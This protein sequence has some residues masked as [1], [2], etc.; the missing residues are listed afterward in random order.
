MTLEGEDVRPT[1]EKVKEAVFSS[2]QFELEGRRVLDLFAGSGQLGI[3]ALSRGA[4]KCVF[5]DS[6]RDAVRVI[7]Q[8][9]AHTG[10]EEE[11]TVLCADSTRFIRNTRETFDVVFIDPPYRHGTAAAVLPDAAARLSPG[12]VI[13]CETEEEAS[14]PDSVGPF[15]K[16]RDRRYGRTR[17]AIYRAPVPEDEA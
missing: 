10:F 2:I 17:V 3:E 12:G 15:V 11:S 9:V 16:D 6:S 7:E 8:N 5:V 13:V 1:T 4:V 14:L